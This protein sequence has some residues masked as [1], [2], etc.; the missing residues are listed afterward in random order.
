MAETE[1]P[2]SAATPETTGSRFARAHHILLYFVGAAAVVWLLTGFYQVKVDEIAIV[3]RLGQYVATPEGRAIPVEHGL[4]YHL[5]WPID[6]VHVISVQQR[7]TLAVKAFNVSPAEYDDFKR[8][9]L[10]NPDNPFGANPMAINAIFNPYLISADK[11]VLHMEISMTFRV[12]DPELWLGSVSHE[13]RETYD[14]AAREDMR[15]QLLQQIAQRA[16]I[17]QAARMPFDQL[18]LQGR[19]SLPQL[20]QTL[21]SDAMVVKTSGAA[22]PEKREEI[23]LGIQVMRVEVTEVR[24]PDAVKP[25]FQEVLKQLSA[26]DTVRSNAEAEAKSMLTRAQGEKETL[27]LDAE[28]YKTKTIQEARGEAERFS[29]VLAQYNNAPDVTR[30]NLFVEAATTVTGNAKRIFFAHPGQRTYIEIDPAQYDA[31]QVKA[32]TNP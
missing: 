2:T 18:L 22:G 25:A 21:L 3:E 8:E 30:W 6:R 12:R 28:S 1:V 5:P 19:E 10:K 27:R 14:P 32:A 17:A 31:N 16:M 13:Y 24:P 15:N 29:Q 23:D 4:H 11:S 20:M 9:Y 26:R 7:L